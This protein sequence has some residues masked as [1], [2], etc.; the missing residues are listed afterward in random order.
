MKLLFSLLILAALAGSASA[1]PYIVYSGSVT[2]NDSSIGNTRHDTQ[3]IYV[4][5][6]LADTSSFAVLL[7]DHADM[8][9]FQVNSFPSASPTTYESNN[10]FFGGIVESNGKS[11]EG[12]FSLDE[13]EGS[14]SQGIYSVTRLYATGGLSLKSVNLVPAR[15][16]ALTVSL[17]ANGVANGTVTFSTLSPA[18]T[19]GDIPF[20]MS[21]S[22]TVYSYYTSNGTDL[23]YTTT[24]TA[25]TLK[26]DA[27]LTAAAN[28]GGG[29]TFGRSVVA[30]QPIDPTSAATPQEVFAAWLNSFALSIGYYVYNPGEPGGGTITVDS[31]GSYDGGVT[32]SDGG[33]GG[34]LT[35][36]G[37]NAASNGGSLDFLG[38]GSSSIG[39]TTL[40]QTGSGTC[41][42]GGTNGYTGPPT[43]SGGI[44]YTNSGTTTAPTTPTAAQDAN[45]QAFDDAGSTLAAGGSVVF[46]NSNL[47]P[48]VQYNGAYVG[49]MIIDNGFNL[50]VG[51]FNAT[52][53]VNGVSNPTALYTNTNQTTTGTVSI[54]GGQIIVSAQGLYTFS[55]CTVSITTTP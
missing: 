46:T 25:V 33:S 47:V 11:G 39:G 40:T 42:L 45:T 20:P 53:V 28:I 16:K 55:G 30:L 2:T 31:G 5:T 54:S 43:I 52:V 24:G 3:S 13:Q 35:L 32:L 41:M 26:E 23:Q 50:M 21:L 9:D 18:I 4:V 10:N 51:L 14:T 38:V 22:G 44:L 49:Q 29:Y 36:I 34:S 6:D 15:T 27:Q 12:V 7:A 19:S 17:K 8:T 37:A 48:G 1:A